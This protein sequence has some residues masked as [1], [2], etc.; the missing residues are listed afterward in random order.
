M[1]VKFG[2]ELALIG[3]NIRA[4]LVRDGL[5]GIVCDWRGVSFSD[6]NLTTGRRVWASQNELLF[7]GLI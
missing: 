7:V 2:I 1:G 6:L 3:S 5:R 4:D